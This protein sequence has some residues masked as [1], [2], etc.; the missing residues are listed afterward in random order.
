MEIDMGHLG[1]WWIL[2]CLLIAAAGLRFVM[3]RRLQSTSPDVWRQL[4]EPTAFNGNLSRHLLEL[5]YLLGARYRDSRDGKLIL[6]GV[7]Y[8]LCYLAMWLLF[9]ILVWLQWG[10]P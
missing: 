9:L 7:V 8:S 1:Y 5:K 4:G 3:I 2:V 10:H 6:V